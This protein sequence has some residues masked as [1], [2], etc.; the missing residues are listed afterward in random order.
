MIKLTKK[1]FGKDLTKIR[2][3]LVEHLELMESMLSAAETN[4][5]DL[6]CGAVF[7][8]DDLKCAIHNLA[9]ARK[10]CR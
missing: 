10:Q 2:L 6:P 1:Q 9:Q 3:M 5:I 8:V 4:K 7:A